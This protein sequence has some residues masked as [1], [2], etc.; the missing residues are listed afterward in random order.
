M[1]N[2]TISYITGIRTH[3]LPAAD[4]LIVI[5]SSSFLDRLPVVFVFATLF[6]TSK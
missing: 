5:F 2:V 1:I 6:G 4:N 3:Y